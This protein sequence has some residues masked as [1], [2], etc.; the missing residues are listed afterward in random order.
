MYVGK[1]IKRVDAFDKVTGRAKFTE[2]L[3]PKDAYT[4]K[5]YHS[6]IAHGKVLSIDTKEAMKVPG[7]VKIV[8]CFDVPKIQFPTAGHPWSTEKDHQDVAD[9]L[10]LNEHVRYY[11]DDV[12]VV[13]ARDEVACKQ[14]LK[15][16]VVEYEEY[17]ANFDALDSIKDVKVPIHEESPDNILKHTTN[18]RGDFEE[19]I[20]EEGLIKVVGD[21]ETPIISH[22]H[23]ENPDVYA[24]EKSGKIVV[25][26]ST[27][28]PHI[29]RRVVGQALGLGWGKIRVIKPYI[30]GGFG[31]KQDALYEPL[32]AFL[33]TQVGGHPVKLLPSREE[34]FVSTRTRHAM[35]IHIESYVR[36]NGDYVARRVE[37]YS[38]G[39]AYASHGH[40]IAA[41]GLNC[42]HQLYP[43]ENIKGDAYSI[44]TNLPAGGAMRGYGIPQA[45]FA[46]EAHHD[47]VAKA[48]GMDPLELKLR[49]VMPKGYVDPFSH[50][51]NYYDSFR[52]C[53]E[54]GAEAI[55]YYAKKEKYK[56][57]TGNI[58]YGI[59]CAVY[60]YNTGVF[61][62]SLESSSC[63]MI[64]NEDGSVQ[65]QLPET[66]I[67]QGADT[68][69]TQMAADSLGM[70]IEDIHIIST[71]DTDVSPFGLGAYASRQTYMAS[72][73]ITKTAKELKEKILDQ[74]YLQTR[75]TPN[76]LDI[77]DSTIVRKTDGRKLL[78]MEELATESLYTLKTENQ[79]ITAETTHT[80]RTN[81]FSFGASFAEVK[82]D[83]DLA[84]VE[85]VK[86]INV[87]DAGNIINPQLAEAQ[88]HG[89]M[90][91]AVGYALTEE[92]KYNDKGRI[93]N[94]N[95]LDY[96][97][98]TIADTP[99]FEVYFIENPEPTS[100]YHTKSL[101]EPPTCSP[102]PAIRNAV[103]NATGISVNKIPM[104]PHVL[105]PLFKEN[106]LIDNDL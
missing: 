80:I 31:N 13:I 41:K 69:F 1:K 102:A 97:L 48:L 74:A 16:I 7:V 94:N 32:C 92:M 15:K 2:D 85:V 101:G 91:M 54:K 63:R 43:C 83:I 90:S 14:A 99:E 26:A 73:S 21:Y 17:P 40:S 77:V 39:G 61:P 52:D 51:E 8:T 89:G 55:D 75:I 79:H 87:H 37:T 46:Y 68:A 33:T 29:I 93:L 58:R 106:G 12:A 30:G 36:K 103:L 25:V 57:Q 56:N 47:D 44:Y 18:N 81:A 96:K 42:F 78:T 86:L 72:F 20:K 59:G 65:I 53:L 35:K 10:L 23:L 104:T 105:F 5:I 38:N 6:T 11:G 45:M 95:L 34:T 60:W 71:Q 84:K 50:N 67:G 82:V 76:N 70:R 22:A 62:I 88:A 4:A 9:R 24:Y 27:Q 49:N 100:P 66:E 3:V 98:G 64:V 19:A 28:I